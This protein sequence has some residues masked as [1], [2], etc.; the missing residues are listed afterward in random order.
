MHQWVGIKERFYFP[1][2]FSTRGTCAV[3]G[4]TRP[5]DCHKN[6][7]QDKAKYIFLILNNI[8]IFCALSDWDN[9]K[10]YYHYYYYYYYYSNY[11]TL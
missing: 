11:N 2:C 4:V 8:Q 10:G 9:T 6:T 5:L 3:R 1:H 7:S